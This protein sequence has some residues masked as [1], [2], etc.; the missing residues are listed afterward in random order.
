MTGTLYSCNLLTGLVNI[1]DLT[2]LNY[3]DFCTVRP[4][5]LWN[6]KTII[7]INI[8]IIN[9]YIYLLLFFSYINRD[10]KKRQRYF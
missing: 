5:V 9:I 1:L 4:V 2:S 7:N 10:T 8:C 6:W 3:I